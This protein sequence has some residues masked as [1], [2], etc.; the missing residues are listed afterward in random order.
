MMNSLISFYVDAS[1]FGNLTHT[2]QNISRVDVT[3]VCAGAQEYRKSC[4]QKCPVLTQ[5]VSIVLIRE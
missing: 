3:K 4:A 1:T 5:E 2:S